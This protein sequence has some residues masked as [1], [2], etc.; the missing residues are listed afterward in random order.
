MQNRGIDVGFG[1]DTC[2]LILY[3]AYNGCLYVAT[4]TKRK[5]DQSGARKMA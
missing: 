3:Y 4:T 5:Y 1:G 2:S